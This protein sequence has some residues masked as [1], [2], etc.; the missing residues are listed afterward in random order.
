MITI[1]NLI[2][3]AVIL[4]VM[5]IGCINQYLYERKCFNKGICPDCGE[6]LQYQGDV[7]GDQQWQCNNCKYTTYIGWFSI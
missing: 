7:D 5:I 2:G 1:L 4:C 3:V 6:M